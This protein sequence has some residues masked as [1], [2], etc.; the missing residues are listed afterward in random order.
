MLLRDFLLRYEFVASSTMPQVANVL[1]LLL[2]RLQVIV[3][4]VKVMTVKGIFHVATT[5]A[6]R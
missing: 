4:K 3:V 6:T 2:L 1:L 5:D